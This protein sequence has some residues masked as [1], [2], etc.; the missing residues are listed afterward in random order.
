M[1]EVRELE[2]LTPSVVPMAEF[3]LELQDDLTE[4]ENQLSFESEEDL[5]SLGQFL[6][7]GSG[8]RETTVPQVVPALETERRQFATPAVD[9]GFATAP[10]ADATRVAIRSS[11]R[12]RKAAAGWWLFPLL[13]LPL[14]GLFAWQLFAGKRDLGFATAYELEQDLEGSFEGPVAATAD[15]DLEITDLEIDFEA[16]LNLK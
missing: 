10:V 2:L 8:R 9:T 7:S 1:L 6:F 11:E 16:H 13:V 3:E 15:A 14:L 12:T 5:E 4:V